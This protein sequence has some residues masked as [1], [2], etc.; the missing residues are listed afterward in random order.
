MKAAH[1]I[2]LRPEAE[3]DPRSIYLG[4]V[5]R[6]ASPAIARGYVSRILG[7]VNGLDLFPKRGSLRDEIRQGLRVIGFERRFSIAFV[8]DED[9]REVVVLRILYA[10]Q[11][12]K[13]D[14]G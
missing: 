6:G 10:G 7:H 13:L 11:E 4:L 14:D 12:L 1:R 8:V 2:R 3:A 5:G 9:A